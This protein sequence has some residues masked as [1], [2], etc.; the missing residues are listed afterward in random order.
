VDF[1]RIVSLPSGDVEAYEGLG[2]G[3][4][5]ELPEEPIELLGLAVGVGLERELSRLFRVKAVE[6]LAFKPEVGHVFL[7]VHP[8]ELVE[9]ELIEWLRSTH[10]ALPSVRLTLEVHESAVVDPVGIG[11]LKERLGSF[12]VGLA[13]DD[14]GAGQARLLELSEVPPDYLKFDMRLVRG[15][16]RAG[17]SRQKLLAS[18]VQVARELSVLTVAEGVETLAEAVACAE[19]GFDFAQGFYFGRPARLDQA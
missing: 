8:S 1:Q 13:Y 6:A 9:P 17:P 19:I 11:A 7:N 16:D 5:S 2:R 18:L 10:E 14:F 12:G 3:T 15:L 4:H